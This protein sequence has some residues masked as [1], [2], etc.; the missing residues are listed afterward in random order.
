MDKDQVSATLGMVELVKA[1]LQ[2]RHDLD[3]LEANLDPNLPGAAEAAQTLSEL[4][5]LSDR[6]YHPLVPGGLGLPI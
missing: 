5:D 3:L 6:W 1:L 2:L 4:R